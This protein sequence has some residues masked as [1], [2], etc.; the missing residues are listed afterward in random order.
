MS[1]AY[2]PVNDLLRRRLQTGL[3]I[4]S[5]TLCVASTLFLLLFGERV[6]TGVFAAAQN[7]L[8]FGF[9][10][11]LDNFM[12]FIGALVF[13]VGVVIVSFT[14]FVMMSQRIRDIGLMKAAGCPNDLVFGYFMTELVI[15]AII[16]CSA[17]VVLALVID[18][19]SA[20]LLSSLGLAIPQTP[21]NYW[22][23]PLVFGVFL[24]IALFLGAKPILD[25]ARVE[26]AKAISPSYYLGLSKEPGV[27]VFSK[28]GLTFKIAMRSLFRR[29][30]ATIRIVLC[31]S[32][33]FLLVTISI[34]GG[35]IADGTTTS[36]IERA[37][38]KDVILIAQQNMAAQYVGLLSKFH[39]TV[40][41]SPFDY[42]N[43]QYAVPESI[44]NYLNSKPEITGADPR[45]VL[46]MQVAEIRNF[47][48]NPETGETIPVG[49]DRKGVSIVVGVTPSKAL[50]D[51]LVEG[52][53]I[54]DNQSREA[55]IGDSLASTM[56]SVPLS[57]G[58][59]VAG[60]DFSTVGLCF[61]PI[62][63]GNVTYVP[64]E[65][66]QDVTG[67]SE[68]NIV[69]VKIDP[70]ADRLQITSQIR[71]EVTAIN[72][73][74][75]VLEL[76]EVLDE[77][78]G[79]LGYIWSSII[80]LPLFSLVA[81]SLC[82]IGYV[83][84]SIAEQRQE[85]GVL[86]ALG[87]KPGTILKIVSGQSFVVLLAGYAVGVA[88]GIIATLLILVPNPFVTNYTVMEIAGWLLVAL[89]ATFIVSLYPALR[90]SKKSLREIMV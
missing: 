70:S 83:M 14:V 24:A 7:R 32:I 35:I 61:D 82:L 60:N 19:G 77:M 56:F 6:G 46:K 64:L 4:T 5:L 67:V 63:N 85:F 44:I 47:T 71:T 33:V 89:I 11:I 54:Q 38:G 9:S 84:L 25:T 3:A 18:F 17:G 1:E 37:V 48:L 73:S 87:A 59:R 53:F 43:V 21:F 29:R 16:G 69:L 74:F 62:N 2:F 68:P 81:A 23:V 39:K 49:D 51:W 22:L 15:T 42:A 86:R 75:V 88:F 58:I 66:L 65:T 8:T 30:S 27:K 78:L 45:L 50:S 36:W 55:M 28:S 79:F 12:L 34:A 52:R 41:D 13:L 57:Q 31:L 76:N 10:A 20:S 90:F 80:L 72:P 40:Q 26:P